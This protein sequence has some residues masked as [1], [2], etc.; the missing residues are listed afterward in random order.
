M[1]F[2][3][4][5]VKNIFFSKIPEFVSNFSVIRVAQNE[6]AGNCTIVDTWNI[7]SFYHQKQAYLEEAK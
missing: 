4:K 5:N 2:R 3:R 1:S 7:L 6:L